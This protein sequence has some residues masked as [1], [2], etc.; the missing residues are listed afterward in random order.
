[1]VSGGRGSNDG[2]GGANSCSLGPGSGSSSGL[3]VRESGGEV[4]SALDSSGI[5]CS[6]TESEIDMDVDT[7]KLCRIRINLK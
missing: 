2:S 3:L 7:L 5:S 6:R 4:M 1:M